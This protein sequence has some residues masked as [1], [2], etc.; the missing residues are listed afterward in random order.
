MFDLVYIKLYNLKF[1]KVDLCSAKHRKFYLRNNSSKR[2]DDGFAEMESEAGLRRINS[3]KEISIQTVRHHQ[4][5]LD[6][7]EIHISTRPFA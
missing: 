7:S 6:L 4:A 1:N 5:G 3:I 2:V